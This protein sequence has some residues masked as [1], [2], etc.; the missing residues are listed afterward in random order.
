MRKV[1]SGKYQQKTNIAILIL[2]K[3][4]KV[5]GIKRTITKC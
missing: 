5:T 4:N 3:T 2:D 1:I